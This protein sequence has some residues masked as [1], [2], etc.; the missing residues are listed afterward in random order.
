MR[1]TGMLGITGDAMTVG[2]HSRDLSHELPI[3]DWDSMRQVANGATDIQ[4]L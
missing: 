2:P 4:R 3:N 1:K